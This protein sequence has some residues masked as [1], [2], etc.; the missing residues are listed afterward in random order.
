MGAFAIRCIAAVTAFIGL[1]ALASGLA[2]AQNLPPLALPDLELRAAAR[3]LD[4]AE[5]PDGGVVVVGEFT[6]IDGVPR[7]YL[8]RLRPD[9]S[10]DPD[11]DLDFG[12]SVT[13]VVVDESGAAYVSGNFYFVNGQPRTRLAK[14]RVN[15]ELDPDWKPSCP[16]A[17]AA[18]VLVGSN[19][20]L[21][22]GQFTE[23]NGQVR[24]NLAKLST[25]GTG[26]LD[27]TWNPSANGRVNA[28]AA[29]GAGSVYVGGQFDTVGGVAQPRLAKLSTSGVGAVDVTWNPVVDGAVHALSKTS[30]GSIYVGGLFSNAGGASRSNIAKLS[31]TGSGL[32]DP[33]WNPGA[34]SYVLDLAVDSAGDVYAAGMFTF[35]GGSQRRYFAKFQGTGTGTADPLWNPVFQGP[36]DGMGM[37]LHIAHDGEVFVGGRFHT[38]GDEAWWGMAVLDASGNPASGPTRA[39]SM[40]T[41]DAFA[42]M[43]DGGVVVGGRF[44]SVGTELRQNL[45]RLTPGGLLD[46]SWTASTDNTV[47]ALAVDGS[48]SLYV[49]GTFSLVSGVQRFSLAKLSAAGAVDPTWNPD[50]YP[51]V[52]AIALGQDGSV[53]VGGSFTFIGGAPRSRIAKLAS[54]GTG[55]AVPD[56]NPGANQPVHALAVSP[57]GWLYAGGTFTQL[58]GSA[59]HQRI[60]RMTVSGAGAVD[61]TWLA[62]ANLPVRSLAVAT[63]GSVF[64]AGWFN[65]INGTAIRGL[66]KLSPVGGS[67]SPGWAVTVD[68]GY[69]DTVRLAEDGSILFGGN[70]SLVNGVQRGRLARLS[71]TGT[72]DMAWNPVSDGIVSA[73]AIAPSGIVYVGGPFSEISGVARR[74]LAALPGDAD[75]IFTHGFEAW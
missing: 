50:G 6:F 11:W 28:I 18:L 57:D 3:V 65:Q 27:M 20:L 47:S 8:A 15:G 49:G 26:D 71:G 24:N 61:A 68:G 14:I 35:A 39:Q 60:G 64:A 62:S 58:G 25:M 2:Q 52:Q 5:Q 23:V 67:V 17:P 59:A 32:A 56:W 16:I 69:G 63:D 13:N 29:D 46:A 55:A 41:A 10:L 73:M 12:G 31:T 1:L 19:A 45:F 43:P 36:S 42:L 44:Q 48:G 40:G 72:L 7:S 74:G 30:A 4:F 70:F 37:A 22:G 9:G 51:W 38:M 54:T 21:I 75:A 34:S 33:V 66:V 53:F